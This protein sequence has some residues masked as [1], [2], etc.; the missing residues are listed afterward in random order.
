MSRSSRS[1][2]SS[3]V[4]RRSQTHAM[5]GVSVLFAAPLMSSLSGVLLQVQSFELGARAPVAGER[6]GVHWGNAHERPRACG[7]QCGRAVRSPPLSSPSARSAVTARPNASEKQHRRKASTLMTGK[8]RSNSA[9][10]GPYL[11]PW[12]WRGTIEINCEIAVPA[13]QN[14]GRP[15]GPLGPP[16]CVSCYYYPLE[17]VTKSYC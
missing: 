17:G 16:L 4:G 8:N 2:P 15:F 1:K 6:V 12:W 14:R 10:R 13:H 5:L 3:E 9:P 11:R 7:R